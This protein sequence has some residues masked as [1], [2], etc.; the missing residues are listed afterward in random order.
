[1]KNINL[2]TFIIYNNRALSFESAL[3]AYAFIF[4]YFF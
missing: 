1:M 4:D 2:S 3:N